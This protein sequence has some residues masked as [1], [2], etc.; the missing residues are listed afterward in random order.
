MAAKVKID[1]LR[2]AWLFT[3]VG[4]ILTLFIDKL[5]LA[6][7]VIVWI[8]LYN[9]AKQRK[10]SKAHGAWSLLGIIGVAIYHFFFAR[11]HKIRN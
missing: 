1:Y 2:R 4:F 11:K 3:I 8:C 7:V 9:D 6:F 10:L 5:Y